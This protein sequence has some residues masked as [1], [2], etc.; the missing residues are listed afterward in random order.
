MFN[1][2][3]LKTIESIMMLYEVK[4][5]RGKKAAAKS[6]NTS[7]DTLNKYLENLEEELGAK[8]LVKSKHRCELTKQGEKAILAAE[9][10]RLCLSEIYMEASS[11]EEIKGQVKIACERNTFLPEL[12]QIYEKYP[13]L[14]FCFDAFETIS[15]MKYC[16]YDICLCY[17]VPKD[18]D[19]VV[20]YTKE[21]PCGFFASKSYVQE[22]G[23]PKNFEDLVSCH[24]LILKR[25]FSEQLELGG[26][27]I[28]QVVSNNSFLIKE[29]VVHS[30]GVGVLPFIQAD[31]KEDLVYLKEV[32]CHIKCCLYLVSYRK[33]KDIPRIRMVLDYYKRSLQ[34]MNF[35][36]FE[37]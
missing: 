21:I 9:K 6:L 24:K 31:G 26:R 25:E 17:A 27:K 10:I 33:I 23:R 37:G 22:H 16:L 19:A 8:L 5:S 36:N 15:D 34:Q 4:K 35:T 28:F 32:P 29:A 1:K 2:K 18:D 13:H 20:V 7:I 12:C 11:K 3:D 14:S 30:V